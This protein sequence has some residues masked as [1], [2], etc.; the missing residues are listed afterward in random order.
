[1]AERRALPRRA[2]ATRGAPDGDRLSARLSA[3]LRRMIRNGDFADG[4]LPSE[5]LLAERYGVGR[6]TV[7]EALLELRKAGLIVARN[8]RTARVAAPSPQRFVG[9]IADA[10]RTMLAEPALMKEFQ[11]ARRLFE[12]GLARHAALHARPDDIAA[13]A[14]TL[15]ENRAA[16]G[17]RAR[18]VRSD[19]AFHAA[20]ADIAGNSL[21][22]ALNGA[23]ADW[24]REQ[25][26][27]SRLGGVD[28]AGVIG[29]HEA[30]FA[31]IR[32]G[33][34]VAAEHAMERHL[35]SVEA[36]FWRAGPAHR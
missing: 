34:A 7:R 12:V 29:E 26:Q 15:A 28:E 6:S 3:D 32:D 33:D 30:I 13:L 27:V 11:A 18:F 24:L 1:M 19:V 9:E 36:A 5:R 35:L 25:R 8:G 20:I 17:Q 22:N 21:F 14:A 4:K 16:T 31:A 10:A 23:F 2:T